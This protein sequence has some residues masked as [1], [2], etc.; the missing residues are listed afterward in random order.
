MI[1]YASEVV[2]ARTPADVWPYLVERDKQAQWSDV[3]MEPLTE[4]PMKAGWRMRLSFGKGPLRTSLTLEVT[5]LDLHER[6]AFTTVS[7][8][9]VQ[10]EGEYRLADA[11]GMSTRLSQRGTLRFSGLWRLAAPIVGA[12]IRR[13]E[14][15]ELEK[16]KSVAEGAPSTSAPAAG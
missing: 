8:G 6:M 12:E 13:G 14:I 2:I 4:G 3:P 10:W 9:G 15:A 7:R 11:D 16:L 5:A 1:T